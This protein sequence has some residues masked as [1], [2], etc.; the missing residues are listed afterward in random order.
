MSEQSGP[1]DPRHGR[2]DVPPGPVPPPGS[3]P[4]PDAP[5]QYGQYGGPSQYGQYGTQPPP[6]GG[7]QPQNQ[8]G[9]YG[10]PA[11]GGY[12]G[13]GFVPVPTA[14]QPGI[15][16]LRPLTL[17]EI[18]D[19][20]FRAIRT[21]PKVMFGLAAL[22]IGIAALL[23]AVFTALF[24][25]ELDQALSSGS[26]DVSVGQT[27]APFL[28]ILLTS[29][30]SGLATLVLEGLAIVSVSESVIGRTITIREVWQ[31]AKG[32]LWRLLGLAVVLWLAA[33]VAFV[34]IIVA[35]A[36]LVG[37]TIQLLDDGAI[38]LL[39]LVPLA[40]LAAF[41][42]FA[43]ITVRV[44]LAT[45]IIMLEG[46]GIFAAIGR[47]WRLTKGHFW[48]LFG[49]M[50]LTGIIVSVL[51]A[52]L[53]VP[54]SMIGTFVAMESLTLSVVLSALGQLAGSALAIPVLAAVL[55]LLYV[56]VRM[57]TEGL[58]VELARAAQGS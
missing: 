47:S 17:G 22:V 3:V 16:P 1:E 18:Y 54:F 28:G 57:R 6:P 25:T 38:I 2:G 52:V 56:D 5:G 48:R 15:I 21:N 26:L 4:P 51:S 44:M 55:A 39:V 29:V 34:L 43:F 12:Y 45:C 35:V 53:S 30:G 14:F 10:T 13:A 7:P 11:D 33:L 23:Q 58:D 49:I 46:T 8:Y 41:A 32:R 9:Q 19:G 24:F 36:V 20:A 31:R 27:V 37:G 40:L 42:V 50:L